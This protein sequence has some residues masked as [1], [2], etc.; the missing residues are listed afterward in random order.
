MLP[1]LDPNAFALFILLAG[2]MWLGMYAWDVRSLGCCPSCG[3]RREGEHS[4]DCHF[5]DKD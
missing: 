2:L 1:V 5:K 4:K 3:S